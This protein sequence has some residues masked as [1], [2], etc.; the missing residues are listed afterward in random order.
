[1]AK[2]AENTKGDFL[3]CQNRQHERELFVTILFEY[4]PPPDDIANLQ[5]Y[6]P[7]NGPIQTFFGEI[8]GLVK[9]GSSQV[10][11]MGRDGVL[12]F[13]RPVPG[14]DRRSRAVRLSEGSVFGCGARNW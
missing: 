7:V 9:M 2:D 5:S 8:G 12:R 13:A 14:V 3:C 4:T 11:E 1:M 6:N 10:V